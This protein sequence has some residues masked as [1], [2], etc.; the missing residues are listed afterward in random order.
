MYAGFLKGVLR[1]L[2]NIVII[3]EH[4]WNVYSELVDGTFFV[5]CSIKI[6]THAVHVP[7]H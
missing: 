1:R 5:A 7:E 3:T 6:V 2:R 4:P